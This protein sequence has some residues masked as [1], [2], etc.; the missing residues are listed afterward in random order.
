MRT[1]AVVLLVC[2]LA[3][4][5]ALAQKGSESEWID[6]PTRL[7]CITTGYD[8]Y[9]GPGG[10][11]GDG[12]PAGATFG[13]VPTAPGNNIQD[14]I[15]YVEIYQTFIGDL[16]VWLMYDIECDGVIDVTGEV[17][18]RHGL[19][20]CPADGCCGCGGDLA[21]WYG[22]DDT[23]A[24]IEDIC[25][26]AFAEGCYGPDYDS[27]GLVVFDGLP[28]GGCFYAF[29][30]DGA[31]ADPTTFNGFEVYVLSDVTPVEGATWGQVKGLYR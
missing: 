28:T 19:D 25:P 21:G 27:S 11:V 7:N 23:E 13:P 17:L 30:A 24:S 8:L 20:G 16:R 29:I 10:P 12:D 18:C 5:T 15:Y 1:I 26:S 31:G 14:V 6:G 4:G 2:L 22:F 3:T 9:V